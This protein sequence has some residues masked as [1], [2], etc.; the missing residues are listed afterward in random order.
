MRQ[1]EFFRVVTDMR[2]AQKEYFTTHSDSALKKSCHLEA[3]VD[4][5]IAEIKQGQRML[6][7]D[8]KVD[9]PT[10]RWAPGS[11]YFTVIASYC[12]FP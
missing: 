12:L 3:K 8:E 4:K 1:D 5:A 9:K 10:A 7:K 2:S 6:F 11:N